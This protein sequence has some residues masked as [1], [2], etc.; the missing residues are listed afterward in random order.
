MI[1]PIEISLEV[2]ERLPSLSLGIESPIIVTQAK[3]FQEKTVTPS[4]YT[5]IVRADDGHD[6]LSSVRVN[7]IPSNYGR[8]TWNGSVLTVS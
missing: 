7:P 4:E 8:I 3:N 6:A 2:E 1:Q 5:Q